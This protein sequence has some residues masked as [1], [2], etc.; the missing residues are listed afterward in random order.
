MYDVIVIGAGVCGCAAARFL[1][2]YEAKVLVLEREEDVCCGTS[3]ANSAIAHAGFDAEPG[4]KMAEYNLK[5]S[6]MMEDLCRELEV[7][8]NRCGS[9]VVRTKNDPPEGLRTLLEKGKANGVSGLEIID[10][11]R[12]VAMEPNISDDAAEALWAPTGAIICPF[13]LTIALAENAA[14]NGAEF[15]FDTDVQKIEKIDG[16][17]EVVT[18]QGSFL[19]KTV[20]NAA[21]VYADRF[22][23]MVSSSPIHITPRRGEYFL[24]DR[25]VGGHVRHTIFQ[26]PDDMGKGV[27]VTQTVHGNLLIGPTALDIEDKEGVNTT[28]AGLQMIRNKA[29]KCVKDIPLRE[30]ITSFAG[31]RAVEDSKDFVLGEAQGA[32]GFFDCAGIASPG[33]TASPA[34]GKELAEQIATKLS[35]SEKKGFRPS[36]KAITK[37]SELSFEER[38]KLIA[39][40]PAYGRIVC[41]CESITEGE[42]LEAI[43]RPLGAK[44][45]DGVKRRTRAGMGRC[46][47]GFCSPRVM[48]LLAEQLGVPMSEITKS[49]GASKLIVDRIKEGLE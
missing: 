24:L 48:Q 14:E 1:S 7:P 15:R 18:D 6:L 23:N 42:I 4:S 43:R 37:P 32:P 2:A 46:Q 11:D 21:G 29:G 38:T 34:L 35:L 27:L 39:Q 17:W 25:E 16:G 31:L 22:H 5:G 45:L 12:L 10:R 47:S 49:G 28:A 44:S 40:D 30:T 33:L 36:R 41:R 19:T 8:Y 3:K 26:L 13:E 20:L 9:L